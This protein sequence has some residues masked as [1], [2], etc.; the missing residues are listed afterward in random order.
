MFQEIDVYPDWTLHKVFMYYIA[1]M[2]KVSILVKKLK[3]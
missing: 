1:N 2:C 3:I